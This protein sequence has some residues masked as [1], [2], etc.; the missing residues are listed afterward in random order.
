MAAALKFCGPSGTMSFPSSVG[1]IVNNTLL[2][3]LHDP[4]VGENKNQ[5]CFAAICQFLE[6]LHANGIKSGCSLEKKQKKSRLQFWVL[7]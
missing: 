2:E 3:E 5:R 4:V 6:A 7:V 1:L